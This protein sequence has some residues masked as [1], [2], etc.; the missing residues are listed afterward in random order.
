MLLL[1]RWN[2]P[3]WLSIGFTGIIWCMAIV[4]QA[5]AHGERPKDAVVE[6]VASVLFSLGIGYVYDSTGLIY[7]RW[8][9][10]SWKG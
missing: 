9:D 10:I 6:I 7:S 5:I 2:L 1:A 3:S 8:W 4:V